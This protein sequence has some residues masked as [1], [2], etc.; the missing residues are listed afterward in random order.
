MILHLKDIRLPGMPEIR[1]AA[2]LFCLLLASNPF[3]LGQRK[4][5]PLG[6]SITQGNIAWPGAN[7]YRRDLWHKLND[8]GYQ[9]DFVGSLDTD[10]KGRTFPD[11]SFDHDHEGHWGWRADEI[12]AE[13]AGWLAGYTP[14]VALIHLGSNDAIQGNTVTSTLDEIGDI[15][16]ILRTDNA[17]ITIFL[18]QILPLEDAVWNANIDGIG[19]DR[20]RNCNR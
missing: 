10:N 12:R 6:N 7:S 18:A 20:Q 19:K 4:I 11:P 16:G 2:I 8:A 13:L 1:K 3:T 9:V 5:V 17:G 15:I 14:D